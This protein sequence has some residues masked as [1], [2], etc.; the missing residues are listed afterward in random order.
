MQYTQHTAQPCTH[1]RVKCVEN[2]LHKEEIHASLQQRARLLEVCSHEL[3]KRH[4]TERSIFD[5][6]GQAGGHVGRTQRAGHKAWAGRVEG[7]HLVRGLTG[8]SSGGNIDF[9]DKS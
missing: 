9:A 3:I 1:L 5:I 4:L 8:Q 2:G 7:S 6:R